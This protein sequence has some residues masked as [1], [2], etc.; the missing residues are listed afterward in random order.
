MIFQGVEYAEQLIFMG[1]FPHTYI[2]SRHVPADVLTLKKDVDIK[3][4]GSP[5]VELIALMS[6]VDE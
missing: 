6:R 5:H 4:G 1:L 2:V 3:L